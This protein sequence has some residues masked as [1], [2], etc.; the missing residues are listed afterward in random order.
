MRKYLLAFILFVLPIYLSGSSLSVH[1]GSSCSRSI[2]AL[3]SVVVLS[4]LLKSGLVVSAA[5][6]NPSDAAFLNS[7]LP[8]FN[9]GGIYYPPAGHAEHAF[10]AV[11]FKPHFEAGQIT[12]VLAGESADFHNS[13]LGAVNGGSPFTIKY[14]ISSPPAAFGEQIDVTALMGGASL[15]AND[16][17]GLLLRA[18][19][20]NGGTDIFGM[21][22]GLNPDHFDH[23]SRTLNLVNSGTGSLFVG[24]GYED[25]WNGGDRD[26]ND[27]R[28]ILIFQP[29]QSQI[30]PEPKT[31]GAITFVGLIAGYQIYL[32]RFR[33]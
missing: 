15:G 1:A 6:L 18:N 26:F 19:G 7:L 16:T 12:L 22:P 11:D 24:G 29:S 33:R 10:P 32:F 21:T 23:L 17:F 25:L 27:A 9:P 13:F 14:D 4:T 5:A 31:W 3:S 8:E 30:I 28:F 20:A 2:R